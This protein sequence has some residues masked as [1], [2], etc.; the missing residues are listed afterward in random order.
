MGDVVN[1]CQ[2]TL[3]IQNKIRFGVCSQELR[4]Q[5]EKTSQLSEYVQNTM[6]VHR[7]ECLTF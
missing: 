7:E 6:I 3:R 2:G 1:M 5:L 4:V